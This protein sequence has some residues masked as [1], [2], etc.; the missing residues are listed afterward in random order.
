MLIWETCAIPRTKAYTYWL[1][2]DYGS[3]KRVVK[4]YNKGE[5]GSLP[6]WV[7]VRSGILYSGNE[8]IAH[9]PCDRLPEPH[10]V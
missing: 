10:T 3:F 9:A 7:D 6:L 2:I 4:A 5:E 8:V 1:T